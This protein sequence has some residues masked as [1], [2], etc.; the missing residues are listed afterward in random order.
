MR[1]VYGYE[2]VIPAEEADM[3]KAGTGKNGD[4]ILFSGAA[5]FLADS[6][7]WKK[8]YC[9][10]FSLSPFFPPQ[11]PSSGHLSST[12]RYNLRKKRKKNANPE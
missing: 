6:I 10:R 9:P 11:P 2:G 1:K 8:V 4:S 7:P 12:T 5:L 3:G